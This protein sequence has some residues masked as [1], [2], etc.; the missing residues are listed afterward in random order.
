[1]LRDFALWGMGEYTINRLLRFYV[2]ILVG[3]LWLLYY[4]L[5]YQVPTITLYGLSRLKQVSL[6]PSK[7]HYTRRLE[8]EAEGT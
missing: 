8:E 1:M 5:A 6:F 4:P 7:K 3:R 2:T